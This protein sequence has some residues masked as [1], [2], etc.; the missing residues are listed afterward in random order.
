M[1]RKGIAIALAFAVLAAVSLLAF[2]PKV[3]PQRSLAP[4]IFISCDEEGNES[5]IYFSIS[6]ETGEV[7]VDATDDAHFGKSWGRYLEPASFDYSPLT[8]EVRFDGKVW[9]ITGE[10]GAR[11]LENIETDYGALW[12]TYYEDARAAS[13]A[14]PYHYER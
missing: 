5:R 7:S 11:T 2:S 6:A 8:G 14:E 10:P 13:E 12:G 9:R 4:A 1:G 3:A